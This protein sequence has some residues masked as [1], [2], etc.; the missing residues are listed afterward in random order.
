M[1]IA[2]DR[3]IP[4]AASAFKNLGDVVLLETTEF[5]A[6]AIREAEILVIRSE[7][8]VSRDLL[9]GTRVR[10]VGTATIGTDHLDIPYLHARGIEFVSAPGSNA[11][12]VKE[13]VLAA[14]LSLAARRGFALRGKTLGIVGIGNVGSKVAR[15][16]R[17]LGMRVLQNDPPLAR[18]GGSAAFVA[19]DELMAADILTLHVP[20]TRTGTDATYHLF[21]A[22]RIAAMKPGSILINT[23]RGAVVEAEALK[24]ALID[25]H[26]SAAVLDVWEGEPTIDTDLL[27]RAALATSHIAGYSLDGKVNAV[28]MIREAVCRFLA[29]STP[30]DPAAELPPPGIPLLHVNYPGSDEDVLRKAILRCYDIELDDRQLRG[31]LDVPPERRGP[32]FMKLRT[33]YRVR[34]EFSRTQVEFSEGKESL[35]PLFNALGFAVES[36]AL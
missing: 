18:A 28:R 15:A 32:Y 29:I 23:S 5:A 20:L 24:N 14:M 22:R 17:E 7:T 35:R 36:H 11:N 9:E 21:D 16:A 10:F 8:R 34:R 12:S 26:C 4:L 6:A 3:N 31:I 2:I 1:R 33:G 13:Y 30:W 27:Q 25:G 19:L